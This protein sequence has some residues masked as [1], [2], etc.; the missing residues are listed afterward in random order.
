MNGL[1]PCYDVKSWTCDFS[2]NGYRMPTEAEWEYAARGGADTYYVFP[3]GNEPDGTKANLKGFDNPYM[4]GDIPHLTPAGFFNGEFHKKEDFNWP[5]NHTTFQ[6]SDGA[7]GYGL[8]D[9]ISNVWEWCNDLMMSDYYA[10]SPSKNPQGPSAEAAAKGSRG[11]N[12]AKGGKS[13]KDGSSE[14]GPRIRPIIRGGCWGDIPFHE[15]YSARVA[16]RDQAPHNHVRNWTLG[17]RVI[18]AAK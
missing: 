7:N 10:S 11:G 5:G 2:K 18:R 8:Y 14:Q 16:E 17:V 1:Q 13:G 9:M 3:W 15:K 4:A 12:T 6:T